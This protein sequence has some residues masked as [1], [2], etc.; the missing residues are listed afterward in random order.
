MFGNASKQFTVT[1]TK[2]TPHLSLPCISPRLL[3]TPHFSA[4]PTYVGQAR[5]PNLWPFLSSR[6]SSPVSHRPYE[7]VKLGPYLL[8]LSQTAKSYTLQFQLPNLSVLLQKQNVGF[9]KSSPSISLLVD[10]YDIISFYITILFSHCSPC[11]SPI[12]R[13]PPGWK[14]KLAQ[15]LQSPEAYNGWLQVPIA[16]S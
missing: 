2:G 10:S 16:M 8:E 1:S 6:V 11:G 12:L 13:D 9:L 4:N 7:P 14:W 3:E 5:V 15:V